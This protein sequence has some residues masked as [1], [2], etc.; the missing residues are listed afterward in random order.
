[1]VVLSYDTG[2]YFHQN[3]TWMCLMDL[4]N[5]TFSIPIFCLIS[6]PSLM[7]PPPPRSVYQISRK[8][9]KRQAH[10]CIPCQC[11]NPPGDI[12]HQITNINMI[13]TRREMNEIWAFQSVS[14]ELW[15]WLYCCI[16]TL[17]Q[18]H[19][20]LWLQVGQTLF[21]S[22][23]HSLTHQLPFFLLLVFNI[24]YLFVNFSIQLFIYYCLFMQKFN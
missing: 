20:I 7:Q 12:P 11:V 18:R 23:L 8:G 22:K 13:S 6:H 5:L 10:I 21:R 16:L 17:R 14:K 15:F 19:A 9:A 3:R 2:G 24:I 4:E 1:M